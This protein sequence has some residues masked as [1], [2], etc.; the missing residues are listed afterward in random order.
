MSTISRF[1]RTP[2]RLQL[3][4][5]QLSI[6]TILAHQD[7]VCTALRHTTIVQDDDLIAVINGPQPMS[8]KNARPSLFFQYAVDVLK[9]ALLG[10][11]I[12]SRSLLPV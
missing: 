5:P 7:I 12:K 9:K 2:R 8:D 3:T 6:N 4:V 1:H 10:V 11:G